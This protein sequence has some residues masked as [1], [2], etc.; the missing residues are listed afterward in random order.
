MRAG[1]ILVALLF[2]SASVFAIGEDDLAVAKNYVQKQNYTMAATHFAKAIA[3]GNKDEAVVSEYA[4][5]LFMSNNF[6]Q[7]ITQYEGL[8]KINNSN[9]FYL[10]R[11]C[12]LYVKFRKYTELISLTDGLDIKSLEPKYSS[13][14]CLAQAEAYEKNYVYPKAIK[15]YTEALAFENDNR[16]QADLHYKIGRCYTEMD[17][18]D[19]AMIS[20]E[21]SIDLDS[22]SPRRISEL[23]LIYDNN[24][25]PLKSLRTFEKAFRQGWPKNWENLYE[26]ASTY[27]TLKDYNNCVAYLQQ[28]QK[29]NPYNQDIASLIAY[30]YYNAGQ[31]KKARGMLDQMLELNPN[32]AESIYL[33]GLTYQ[34]EERMDKAENYFERAFKL[35]PSLEKLR[36]SKMAF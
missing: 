3:A 2:F 20:Y 24:T 9:K 28:A 30:S 32:H 4:N 15:A 7:A 13:L 6:A 31:T 25:M 19:K 26:L 1:T 34:K 21:R 23:A 8:R 35:K 17:S 5:A 12:E 14:I 11:L 22:S 36:V 16:K 29:E 10:S 27:Y 33:Y 18:W